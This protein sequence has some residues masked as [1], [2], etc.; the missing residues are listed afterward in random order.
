MIGNFYIIHLNIQEGNELDGIWGL[1]WVCEERPSGLEATFLSRMPDGR[2][3][4]LRG[5]EPGL[6]RMVG[7]GACSGGMCW[8]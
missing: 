3:V 2:E 7:K 4:P 8:F 5:E 1:I 6:G